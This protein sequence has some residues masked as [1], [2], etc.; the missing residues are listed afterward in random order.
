MLVPGSM[1]LEVVYSRAL[2][3]MDAPPWTVEVYLA[4]GLPSF[5]IVGLPEAEV[6]EAKDRV[7]AALQ[8]AR[9]DFPARRI[10]GELAPAFVLPEANAR[11]AALVD[12]ATVPPARSL[13]EVCAHLA[14][15][16]PL[17]RCTERPVVNGSDYL[18]LYEVKGQ[19]H[20]QGDL[21]NRAG[22]RPHLH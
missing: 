22:G 1:S 21:E 20:A 19:A 11:E 17:V 5:T 6:K 14:G 10:T 12:D 16:A 8:N 15:R 4:N 2:A 18:D 13:L 3:G 9:F 7:R